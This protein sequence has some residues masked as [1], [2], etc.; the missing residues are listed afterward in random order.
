[1]P[2][3]L[4]I[5]PPVR[6]FY[7]TTKRTIPYGLASI[8]AS[9]IGEGFSVD[10]L[11]G[12]ATQKSRL[13]ELPSEMAYLDRFY[14]RDDISPF[15]LFNGFKHFGYSFQHIGTRAKASGAFLV[16][17]SSLFTPYAKEALHAAESVKKFHPECRVVMGG[18]HPTFFPKQVMA[19][20][21][22]DFVIRGEGEIAMP[23]LAGALKNKTDVENIPGIVF[24]KENGKIIINEPV[25]CEDLD[26]L[27]LPA[28]RL[29]KKN[30]Y[31]RRNRNSMMISAGRGCPMKCSYCA[32]TVSSW[33]GYRRRSVD[34]V[35]REIDHEAAAG[36]L[37][38]IDFEDENLSMDKKWF[39]DLLE[40]LGQRF[41]D[42]QPELRAMNGPFPPSLDE[43]IVREMKRAGFR[44]LNLSL[45]SSI[46]KQLE[47]F[48]R[49]DVRLYFDRAIGIAE[50]NDM[51]AV[52]YVIAGA[53]FQD[54]EQSVDD[55]LFLM[56]RRVLAGVS[57]FYPAPGSR[58]YELCRTKNLLPATWSLMRSAALPISH[59]TSR[60]DSVTLLRLGRITNF[61]KGL[62][63][64]HRSIPKGCIPG[65][66][67]RNTENRENIGIKLISWF[68]KDGKIRGVGSDGRVFVHVSSL[69]LV[70][71]F[72]S[73]LEKIDLKG[74]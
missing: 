22:V 24:T 23:Q 25:V 50:K 56:Q 64:K 37:G 7:L 16:G 34:S 71:R 33:M 42:T 12:L 32:T 28:T 2:D 58:D 62:I 13:I 9:L 48:N 20:P 59:S 44:T 30:Y 66:Y 67:I 60:L 65:D 38:F 11:D 3:V 70:K 5:Q 41:G 57:I 29:I 10:L 47:R 35:V 43:T 6:D 45:G 49:P 39:L 72:L 53:P 4:L 68:R 40:K 31:K 26:R 73:G 8:A 46:V 74:C 27:P 21:A 15:C 63:S 1:M 61:I 17:I 18:H 55:L 14:G 54:P 19:H 51:D 69:K 36:D 52:G